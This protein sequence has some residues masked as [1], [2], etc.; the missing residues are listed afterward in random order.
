MHGKFFR[1][2]TENFRDG[3]HWEAVGY[4]V[5]MPTVN[6]CVYCSTLLMG[7]KTAAGKVKRVNDVVC[8]VQEITS[9]NLHGHVS[10]HHWLFVSDFDF[11]PFSNK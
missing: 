11:Y 6:K 9:I 2:Q 7:E 4:C 1:G 10:L 3:E 5:P 8:F